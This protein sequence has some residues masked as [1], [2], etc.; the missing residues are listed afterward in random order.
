MEASKTRSACI[1]D[2]FSDM[3]HGM[4]VGDM[5]REK[6]RLGCAYIATP[7]VAPTNL[8]QAEGYNQA[9]IRIRLKEV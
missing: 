3:G 6:F 4:Q 1:P 2:T 8:N 5:P 7:Q 9:A